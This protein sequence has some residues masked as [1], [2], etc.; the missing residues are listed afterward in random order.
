MGVSHSPPDRV[1]RWQEAGINNRR[2]PGSAVAPYSLGELN[3]TGHAASAT[4]VTLAFDVRNLSISRAPMSYA[5]NRTVVTGA[6]TNE[7]ALTAS[8]GTVLVRLVPGWNILEIGVSH[9]G[10]INFFI[11]TIVLNQI[12]KRSHA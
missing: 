4:S 2:S 12:Q 11:D 9:N 10:A 5:A 1:V 6:N 3:F 7:N 8:Q